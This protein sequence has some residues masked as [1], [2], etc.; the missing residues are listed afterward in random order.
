MSDI[1]KN[2]KSSLVSGTTIGVKSGILAN[3]GVSCVTAKAA[4]SVANSF[5]N[6]RLDISILKCP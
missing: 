2:P 4:G 1:S 3:A 5:R 6:P